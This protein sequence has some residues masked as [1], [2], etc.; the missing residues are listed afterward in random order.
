M[1]LYIN[2]NTISATNH[3]GV[4]ARFGENSKDQTFISFSGGRWLDEFRIGMNEFICECLW[5]DRP[6]GEQFTVDEDGLDVGEAGIWLDFI[7]DLEC[8]VRR[9]E[10][11]PL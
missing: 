3:S 7:A 5:G 9:R 6:M 1:K 8:M 10:T 2:K 4:E 11:D